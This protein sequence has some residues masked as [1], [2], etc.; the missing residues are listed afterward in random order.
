MWTTNL[1]LIIRITNDRTA[2][3]TIREARVTAIIRNINRDLIPSDIMLRRVN[4]DTHISRS[5]TTASRAAEGRTSIRRNTEEDSS[6]RGICVC[7]PQE[8]YN[9][10]EW[11]YSSTDWYYSSTDWNYKSIQLN[12]G[13]IRYVFLCT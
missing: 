13:K 9:T 11:Y 12:H 2:A 10:I 3:T 4:R 6:L 1:Y 7:F 8:K 5:T